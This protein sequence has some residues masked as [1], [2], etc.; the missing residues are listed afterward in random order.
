MRRIW[1][2]SANKITSESVSKQW[3][4]LKLN[5]S[6]W[7]KLDTLNSI[8]H[9]FVTINP[10]AS[11]DLLDTTQF[12]LLKLISNYFIIPYF[13]LT[14]LD[15]HMFVHDLKS[16]WT[17]NF[18]AMKRHSHWD[19]YHCNIGENVSIKNCWSVTIAS[20]SAGS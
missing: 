18:L 1:L 16:C 7:Q 15:L 4:Q 6:L 8:K 2:F 3:I 11:T 9:F 10:K 19:I 13:Y 12:Y 5:T 17:Y 20:T 14:N